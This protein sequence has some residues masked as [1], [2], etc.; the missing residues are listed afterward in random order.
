MLKILKSKDL[1]FYPHET[2]RDWKEAIHI[3]CEKLREYQYI[4]SKYIAEIIDSV[5]THG[6]YIVIMP[7]IAMPHAE[8]NDESVYKSGISFT[9]FKEPVVFFDKKTHEEKTAIL[10]FALAAKNADE[11]LQNIM[12]L[13]ELLSDEKILEELK[14]TNSIADFEKVAS[15]N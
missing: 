11:H 6:P 10:F 8:G 2:P 3:S 4:S 15:K 7:D 9:K 14:K 12:S 5:E 1:V 13:T